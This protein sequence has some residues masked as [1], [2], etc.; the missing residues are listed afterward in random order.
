[1]ENN[2]IEIRDGI[3]SKC[4]FRWILGIS[5]VVSVAL[6]I[7]FLQNRL[8]NCSWPVDNGLF[9]TY[10]DFVGGVVGTIIAFYSAYL[11]I[12]TFQSQEQVNMH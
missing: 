7:L 10:G 4:L 8:W 12:R 11:L 9:G 3:I 1:M 6:I 5:L 2:S